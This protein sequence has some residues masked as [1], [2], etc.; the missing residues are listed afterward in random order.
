[1]QQSETAPHKELTPARQKEPRQED[2]LTEEPHQEVTLASQAEPHKEV[3][4]ACQEEPQKET[5]EELTQPQ[6]A[7]GDPLSYSPS[8][9]LDSP[10][11]DQVKQ[12]VAPAALEAEQAA[13]ALAALAAA[14]ADAAEDTPEPPL[15]A[16]A[17][18]VKPPWRQPPNPAE[19]EGGTA[20]APAGSLPEP[21]GLAA[22]AGTR[23]PPPRDPAP[24]ASPWPPSPKTPP[25]GP[26]TT[27][28]S[29]Q[30]TAPAAVP[31][32]PP[33]GPP[34]TR[35][36]PL[37]ETP[38][39]MTSSK[40]PFMAPLFEAEAHPG[41]CASSRAAGAA[42]LTAFGPPTAPPPPAPAPDGPDGRRSG[43]G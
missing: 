33:K 8:L 25:M 13:A 9:G 26:P 39:P 40:A 23:V 6:A 31:K 5:K 17:E 19:P 38:A 14:A 1:A 41:R 28:E 34:A 27:M 10:T 21:G 42:P 11:L 20:A 36:S 4:L 12:E 18:K 15:A 22:E 30:P 7:S 24:A 16:F 35:V 37:P 3:T 2:S 32:T 29:P 43:T